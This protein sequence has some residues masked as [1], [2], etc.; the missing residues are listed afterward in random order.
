MGCH[1][2]NVIYFQIQ[3]LDGL[4]F[5]LLLLFQI[6]DKIIKMYATELITHVAIDT[7]V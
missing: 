7:G 5:F 4:W 3:D 1:L 2:D 6:T